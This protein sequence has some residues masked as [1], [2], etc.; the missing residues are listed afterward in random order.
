M[1]QAI[2][3]V[4][5]LCGTILSTSDMEATR[6]GEIANPATNSVMA[7]NPRLGMKGRGSIV[8]AIRPMPI[9]KR[10]CTEERHRTAPVITPASRLPNA[11]AASS[12]PVA[13]G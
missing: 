4:N 12:K 13:T 5:R 3:S 7:I 8:K 9:R 6:V 1:T 11:Q 2:P 10:R